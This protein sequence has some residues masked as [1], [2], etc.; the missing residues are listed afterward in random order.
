MVSGVDP[1]SKSIRATA[2][3]VYDRCRG[4]SVR[5]DFTGFATAALIAWKLIV[6]NAINVA[7][8]PAIKNIHHDTP[9][10]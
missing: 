10:R 8:I 9:V 4:Y 6:N 7:K 3:R 1:R 2:D 5:S